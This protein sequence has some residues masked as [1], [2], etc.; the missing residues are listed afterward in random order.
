MDPASAWDETERDKMQ[1]DVQL[2][3]PTSYVPRYL[4]SNSWIKTI[5]MDF[6]Q[7]GSPVIQ[8]AYSVLNELPLH[9]S[10]I[11]CWFTECCR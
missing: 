9:P 4:G 7:F 5:Q 6:L 10:V 3:S 1:G 2:I 8:E 11:L